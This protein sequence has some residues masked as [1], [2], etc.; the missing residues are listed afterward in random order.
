MDEVGGAF[1]MQGGSVANVGSVCVPLGS[2]P[3]DMYKLRH[4][5]N[6]A[7][8]TQGELM[9][10][11]N[12]RLITLAATS[13]IGMCGAG[14]AIAA[15]R[16]ALDASSLTS[17]SS[18]AVCTVF[19]Y[20]WYVDYNPV[21]YDANIVHTTVWCGLP[22]TELAMMRIGESRDCPLGGG[23]RRVRRSEQV[24]AWIESS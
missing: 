2:V 16:S 11:F 20:D 18:R 21:E 22:Q 13:T 4:I 3:S 7:H 24:S 10:K 15:T 12:I 6:C 8:F 19:C 14:D 5:R 23:S 17:Q 9:R 1:R